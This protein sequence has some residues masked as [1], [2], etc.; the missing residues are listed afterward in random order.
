[1]ELLPRRTL[2]A[3]F[4]LHHVLTLV[5]EWVMALDFHST[6]VGTL[7]M[8]TVCTGIG[9]A[10]CSEEE[11][12]AALEGV[13]AIRVKVKPLDDLISIKIVKAVMRVD[14]TKL[15]TPVQTK[16]TVLAVGMLLGMVIEQNFLLLYH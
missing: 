15:M 8:I 12:V 4:P 2:C 10:A 13:V 9:I 11:G 5:P 3:L 14:T 16:M 7:T 6:G 1:M